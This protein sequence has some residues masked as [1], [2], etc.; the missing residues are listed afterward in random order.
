MSFYSA[1]LPQQILGYIIICRN[2]EGVH[3]QRNVGNSCDNTTVSLRGVG[4]A[5]VSPSC[6][7]FMTNSMLLWWT[8]DS[9]PLPLV[10]K[11]KV[12]KEALQWSGEPQC[13]V[14][15]IKPNWQANWTDNEITSLL[16]NDTFVRRTT[17]LEKTFNMNWLL[18]SLSVTT[19]S[20]AFLHKGNVWA[21][22]YQ[23]SPLCLTR[24][25]RAA[26]GPV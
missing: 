4:I 2:V 11:P 17:D 7:M 1:F 24:G 10:I 26:C 5:H 20:D 15:S 19:I 3:G 6:G 21:H 14:T 9:V 8:L 13:K 12:V 23:L 18:I 25:P 22:Y 16:L